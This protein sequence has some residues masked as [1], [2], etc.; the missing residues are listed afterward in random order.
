[1]IQYRFIKSQDRSF[2]IPFPVDAWSFHPVSLVSPAFGSSRNKIWPLVQV[3]A[4]NNNFQVPPWKFQNPVR[5]FHSN[6]SPKQ[7]I[8]SNSTI[9]SVLSSLLTKQSVQLS[10]IAK[11][12]KE[13]NI[14][15]PKYNSHG[16]VCD[17]YF[18]KPQQWAGWE[19]NLLGLLCATKIRINL[20]S[21]TLT[22]E[23]LQR[24]I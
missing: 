9:S 11:K 19:S 2:D 10:S 24:L 17:C 4:K 7:L 22:N 21:C 13:R 3:Q 12:N 14:R 8:F 1:M 6:K 20:S 18:S 16:F 23:V 5:I 15:K